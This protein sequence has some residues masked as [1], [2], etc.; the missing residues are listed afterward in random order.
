MANEEQHPLQAVVEQRPPGAP[1]L[2]EVSRGRE[3]LARVV[4]GQV[5]TTRRFE[6]PDVREADNLWEVL[7]AGYQQSTAG[8]WFR[9]QPPEVVLGAN[10]GRFANIASYVAQTVGDLPTLVL[11]GVGGGLLGSAASPGV[12]TVVG[13][14]AGAE[15]LTAG[16]RAWLL[17][18]Y[19]EGKDKRDLADRITATAW[20]ATKGALIGGATAGA[21]KRALDFARTGVARER[22]LTGAL[23]GQTLPTDIVPRIQSTLGQH[24]F[25]T[26]AEAATLVGVSSVLERELPSPNDFIMAA[27]TL[28]GLKFGIGAGV[29]TTRKARQAVRSITRKPEMEAMQARLEKVYERTGVPPRQVVQDAQ[30][31]PTLWQ[32]LIDDE[33]QAIP[34]RYRRLEQSPM[35]PDF[36]QLTPDDVRPEIAAIARNPL[37]WEMAEQRGRAH[38]NFDTFDLPDGPKKLADAITAQF[39]DEIIAETRGRVPLSQTA[40]EAIDWVRNNLGEDMLEGADAPGT[41]NYAAEMMAR[42]Y[43]A[44]NALKDAADKAIQVHQKGEAATPAEVGEVLLAVERAAQLQK[45]FRGRTAELGRAMRALRDTL[46][47]PVLRDNEEAVIKALEALGGPDAARTFADVVAQIQDPAMLARVA[48]QPTTFEKVVFA[49]KSGMLSAPE[50]MQ[51]TTL[52]NLVYA[53]YRIPEKHLAAMVGLLRPGKDRVAFTDAVAYTLGHAAGVW[54]AFQQ[55]AGLIRANIESE[56]FARGLVASWRQVPYSRKL[57]LMSPDR[58]EAIRT[59]AERKAKSE[60]LTEGTGPFRSRVAEI[61]NEI[62]TPKMAPGVLDDIIRIPFNVASLGDAFSSTIIERATIWEHAVRQARKDG[63]ELFSAGWKKRVAELTREPPRSAQEAARKMAERVSFQEQGKATEVLHNIVRTFPIFGITPLPFR[64]AAAAAPREVV[65]RSPLAPFIKSWREDYAKGGAERDQALA[66]VVA[67]SAIGLMGFL[68]AREGLL[69]GSGHPDDKQRAA[70]YNAGFQPYS[71]VDREGNQYKIARWEPV[72]T[73]LGLAADVAT[74]WDIMTEGEREDAAMALMWAGR[75]V[76]LNKTWLFGVAN[77]IGAIQNPQ[78]YGERWAEGLV[79][80]IVPN[81]I[82]SHARAMDPYVREVDGILQSVKS[83]IPGLR[84]T[85][86]IRRDGFGQPIVP[87]DRLWPGSPT[88]VRQQSDDPVRRAAAEV[89]AAMPRWPDELHAGSIA[90]EGA[91]VELE[92]GE[93]DQLAQQ[94]GQLA[95]DTM[96]RMV[97]NPGWDRLPPIYRRQIFERVFSGARKKA[98]AEVLSPEDREAAI[99]ALMEEE[100]LL[101]PGVVQ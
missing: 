36:R 35:R 86:T 1:P 17:Q 69:T 32:Q 60:G 23:P 34:N 15:G 58:R 100:G 54:E 81:A 25:A 29:A 10:A 18:K 80:P 42:K 22:G 30:N 101:G 62:T 94:A 26:T 68:L 43:L 96:R 59:A 72:G 44:Q 5:V 48:R 70:D 53:A 52:G 99:R 6:Q 76:F 78:M 90:G 13:A 11:G 83:R 2:V 45:S 51:I 93:K 8:L 85:L 50:T 31:D 65:R 19:A 97:E 57:D 37:K 73:M 3:S 12:G 38:L 71:L 95:Y 63:H 14:G 7:Q 88:T 92:P 91:R 82:A 61:T 98:A 77:M 64:T 55:A 27:V 67:G 84:E 87:S 49:I 89:G 41:V 66:E 75:E 20:A 4:E 16:T 24:A 56:G 39:R 28:G 47:D 40:Q 46:Q 79:A 9:E 33:F 74:A 21:G